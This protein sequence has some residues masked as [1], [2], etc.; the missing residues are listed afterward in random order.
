MN[1]RI[2]RIAV[3]AGRREVLLQPAALALALRENRLAIAGVDQ[4]ALA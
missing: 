3:D 4:H 2:D 1:D